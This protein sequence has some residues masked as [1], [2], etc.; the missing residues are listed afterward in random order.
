MLRSPQFGPALLVTAGLILLVMFFECCK[1]KKGSNEIKRKPVAPISLEF[2]N[3]ET[4]LKLPDSTRITITDPEG[5]ILL[6]DR[7]RDTSLLVRGGI[8]PLVFLPEGRDVS[9]DNPY[10]FKIEV[11]AADYVSTFQPIVFYTLAP[12]AKTI[13]VVPKGPSVTN[14]FS[15]DRFSGHFFGD[16]LD[17]DLIVTSKFVHENHI[18]EVKIRAKKGLSLL[19]RSGD[20]ITTNQDSL[21]LESGLAFFSISQPA[22]ARLFPGSSLVTD[23]VDVNGETLA[24]P[25]EPVFFMPVTWFTWDLEVGTGLSK[26]KVAGFSPKDA[27]V[28]ITLDEDVIN[29][30]TGEKLRAGDQLR[31]WK[32]IRTDNP[33]PKYEEV[34][35]EL[36]VFNDG[37][38]DRP[39]VTT[40]INSPGTWAFGV[41][42]ENACDAPITVYVN[43]PHQ[44]DIMLKCELTNPI[45]I[46]NDLGVEEEVCAGFPYLSQEITFQPNNLYRL[47]IYHVPAQTQMIF[48]VFKEDRG[49]S[50]IA[51]DSIKIFRTCNL[52]DTL[53]LIHDT[54]FVCLRMEVVLNFPGTSPRRVCDNALWH[55]KLSEVDW[56]FAGFFEDGEIQTMEIIPKIPSGQTI[57]PSDHELCIWY[58][59]DTDTRIIFNLPSEVMYGDDGSHSIP[60]FNFDRVTQ[61]NGCI[62]ITVTILNGSNLRN[63]NNEPIMPGDV[64]GCLVSE[65]G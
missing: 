1:T 26:T 11:E 50:R 56:Q 63:G 64:H 55:K 51:A 31:L 6:P 65:T 9:P 8:L 19:D 28:L 37:S 45:I 35:S 53:E 33:G 62:K 2:V 23:L 47:P 44:E 42:N 4:G 13:R 21:A 32:L 57:P 5:K 27:E 30:L 12:L 61:A 36:E 14:T 41:V 34:D 29:P 20:P 15:F 24:T 52:P 3:A 16:E 39:S 48:T 22:T 7:S 40:A 17:E 10:R 43:N 18:N 54:S 38:T 60:N 59:T 58:N 49:K 46:C 25:D